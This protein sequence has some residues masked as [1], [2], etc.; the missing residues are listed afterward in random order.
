MHG[1][2]QHHAL[3]VDHWW[4]YVASSVDGRLAGQCK[5]RLVGGYAAKRY[6]RAIHG[7][8]A[9][10]AA[11]CCESRMRVLQ[12]SKRSKNLTVISGFADM[13]D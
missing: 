1:A 8:S 11:A 3:S 12:R 13:S 7:R 6:I 4:Q 5:E 9:L 10:I 2:S